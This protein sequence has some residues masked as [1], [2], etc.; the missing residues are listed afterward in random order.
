VAL[1]GCEGLVEDHLGL[2]MALLAIKHRSQDREVGGHRRYPEAEI[3]ELAEELRE[4]A[5]T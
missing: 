3:R 5:I 1:E 2:V 4:E